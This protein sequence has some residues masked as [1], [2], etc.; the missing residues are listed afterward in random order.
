MGGYT[1][2]EIDDIQA[3]WALRFPPDLVDLLRGER[4]LIG[5]QGAFDWIRDDPA[6]IRERLEWPFQSFWF[7]VEHNGAWWSEWG[8]KPEEPA[9]QYEL[10]R[11]AFAAAPGRIPWYGHR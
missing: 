2:T 1:A 6:T 8:E 10:L 5:G 7:D 11:A 3:F 4:P 9:A